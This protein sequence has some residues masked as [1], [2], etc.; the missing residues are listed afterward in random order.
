MKTYEIIEVD[1][2]EAIKCLLCGAVSH[3]A[4]DVAKLYCGNCH[5][6]HD[7]T[8]IHYSPVPITEIRSMPQRA[9][10]DM[11]PSGLWVSV[12]GPDDWKIWCVSEGF[13]T[14]NLRHPYQ[15]VLA[16]NANIW[17]LSSAHQI[18]ELT[19]KYVVPGFRGSYHIDWSRIAQQYE[20]IIAPYIW[21]RRL[22][23]GSEWYYTWDCASGCIWEAT[24]I[25]EIVPMPVEEVA[26]CSEGA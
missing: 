21:E 1:G 2:H 10:P 24:A 23:G 4:N 14:A 26:E 20:G 9:R 18:D 15:I 12:Q 11:K 13:N 16:E 17:R 6:F 22:F 7:L 8:L 25:K 5:R 19:K 3:N